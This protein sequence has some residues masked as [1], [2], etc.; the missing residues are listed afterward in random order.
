MPYIEYDKQGRKRYLPLK[1]GPMMVFGREEYVEFQI[2]SD[3]AISR[4]HCGIEMNEDGEFQLIDLGASNGTMV[5]GTKLENDIVVLRDGDE[6][7]LGKVKL[8]YRAEIPRKDTSDILEETMEQVDNGKGFKT[9][10][11]EIVAKVK[12]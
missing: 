11:G 3:P 9:L 6:I 10:M 8:F 12:P 1:K 2:L 7:K 5:N 4:E